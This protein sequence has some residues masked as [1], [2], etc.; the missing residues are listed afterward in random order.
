LTLLLLPLLTTPTG[1][2]ESNISTNIPPNANIAN[3]SSAETNTT[4]TIP[5]PTTANPPNRTSSARIINTTSSLHLLASSLDLETTTSPNPTKKPIA[6]D[7]TWRYARSKLAN[8]L[9]TH[10]LASLLSHDH[11]DKDGKLLQEAHMRRVLANSFFPGNIATDAMS[12]WRNLLGPAGNIVKLGFSIPFVGQTVEQ[13]ATTALYLAASEQVDEE[14]VGGEYFVPIATK[15]VASKAA[16]D[17]KAAMELWD[18]SMKIVT[19]TLGEGWA[20]DGGKSM[21]IG[22]GKRV[23]SGSEQ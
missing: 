14:M 21:N 22:K 17:D 11:A 1:S 10:R 12:T 4:G 15:G 20:A 18:W 23:T 6:W 3:I 2:T 19:E 7:S 9:F 5:P 13:A 16:T 8:I